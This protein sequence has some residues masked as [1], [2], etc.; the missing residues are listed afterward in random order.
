MTLVVAILIIIVP[1][2]EDAYSQSSY[3]PDLE[4][5]NGK[6]DII[7]SYFFYYYSMMTQTFGAIVAIIAMIATS[8]IGDSQNMSKDSL[9]NLK[10]KIKNF[11]FLYIS[12]I[13]LSIIGLATRALPP[14]KQYE[15]SPT[16]LIFPLFIF[17]ATLLLSIPALIYLIK[18]ILDFY[19]FMR[20]EKDR[21]ISQPPSDP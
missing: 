6:E 18:L 21:P 20:E 2:I 17:E 8:K 16:I 13:I 1:L 19:D 3:L 7:F 10:I 12:I 11:L 15:L 14:L 5:R 9:D 4:L